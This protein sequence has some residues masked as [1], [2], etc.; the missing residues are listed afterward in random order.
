M[1]HDATQL[2]AEFNVD[3]DR[4]THRIL[5]SCDGET[6][7][8]LA[9]YEGDPS[10]AWPPSPVVQQLD[11]CRTA[12]G[13]ESLVAVGMAGVSHWSLAVDVDANER[14]IVFDIA[15]RLK[16]PADFLG[17][18]YL[19]DAPMDQVD[20]ST[21][22]IGARTNDAPITVA[23]EALIGRV[24]IN[25]SG[26]LVAL[27]DSISDHLPTTVRWKYRFLIQ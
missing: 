18:T 27:P 10:L 8:V 23:I 16:A 26:Q 11:A 1:S 12:E 19:V 25:Q 6:R 9:S 15:C 7:A 13:M 14:A 3:H 20:H 24:E 5:Q 4:V 2:A 22:T 21:V 17:S